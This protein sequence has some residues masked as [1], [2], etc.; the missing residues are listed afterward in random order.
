MALIQVMATGKKTGNVVFDQPD[1]GLER[2]KPTRV[3]I[4][5]NGNTYTVNGAHKLIKAALQRGDLRQ[6]GGDPVELEEAER[7]LE[8]DTATERQKVRA[9]KVV[10]GER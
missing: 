1:A 4:R 8:S 7:V 2:G 3:V 6:V 9:Q 10:E 5:A